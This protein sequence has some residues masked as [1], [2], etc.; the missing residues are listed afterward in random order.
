MSLVN[1]N[2]SRLVLGTVQLGLPYGIANSTGKPDAFAA[3]QLIQTAL[4]CGITEFDTAADYGTS[5]EVLGAT[6]KN[7]QNSEPIK[8]ITKTGIT[9]PLKIEDSL[10]TSLNN[11]QVKKVYGLLFHKESILDSLSSAFENV[12]I[13]LKNKNSVEKIGI[14]VYEPKNALV[15][16]NS[17]LF[18]IVQFPA[19]ILDRRFLKS[20]IIKH[21]QKKNV[22][23]YIR[24]VFLQGF[25]F[26]KPESLPQNMQFSNGTLTQLNAV[27]NRVGVPLP[28][29][30][31][32]YVK[33]TFPNAKV[34]VGAEKAEQV[35]E[36]C[37]YWQQDVKHSVFGEIDDLIKSMDTRII[38]PRVWPKI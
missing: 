8:I 17:G 30:S 12:I 34:I 16:I 4:S 2:N 10:L 7:I 29:L 15:A 1:S 31:M 26:L 27:A 38:D 33:A 9:D 35:K 37:N 18:D 21:A 13:S 25:F 24:S 5:E 14:S 3:K 22:D 19:N 6:L 28:A 23:L 20:D 36:L 32:S 11:L